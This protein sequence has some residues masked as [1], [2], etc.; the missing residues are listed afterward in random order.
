MKF[1]GASCIFKNDLYQSEFFGIESHKTSKPV[2]A[3][4]VFLIASVSKA[5]TAY[6]IRKLLKQKSIDASSSINVLPCFKDVDAKLTFEHLLNHTSGLTDE[7]DGDIDESEFY[8]KTMLLK[9]Y[10]SRIKKVEFNTFFYANVNY[11][12]LGIAIEELS[13]QTLESQIENLIFKPNSIKNAGFSYKK[14]KRPYSLA[15]AIDDSKDIFA[16]ESYKSHWMGYKG[17][18]CIVV[19]C[20][21][22]CKLLNSIV[23]DLDLSSVLDIETDIPNHKYNDGFYIS[24]DDKVF[25]SG[26]TWPDGFISYFQYDL[27]TNSSLCALCNKLSH[28]DLVSEF[29]NSD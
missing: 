25:I 4:T 18:D 13:G 6:C 21:E 1:N 7:I 3:N 24:S 27:K 28:G 5:F 16:P 23:K 14:P 8:D 20:E 15:Y 26:A 2:D 29:I 11:S 19:T 9:Q 17:S 12:L 10:F 22:L